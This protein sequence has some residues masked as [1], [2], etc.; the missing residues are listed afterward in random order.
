MAGDAGAA[1]HRHDRPVP[2]TAAPSVG[3]RQ[4]ML[5]EEE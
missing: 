1:T 5:I 4:Q 2:F 3:N